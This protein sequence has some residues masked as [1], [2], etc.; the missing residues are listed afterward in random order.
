[1]G[2]SHLS[3]WFLLH[4]YNFGI[5]IADCGLQD[6]KS[7]TECGLYLGLQNPKSQIRNPKSFLYCTGENPCHTVVWESTNQSRSS[8]G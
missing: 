7:K 6:P 4:Y 5:R 8:V 2:N 1:M 3:A